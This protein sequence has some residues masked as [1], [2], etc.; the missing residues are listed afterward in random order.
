MLN[1]RMSLKQFERKV[2][3]FSRAP[4][5]CVLTL[6]E[7]NSVEKHRNFFDLVFFKDVRNTRDHKMNFER[8]LPPL[9]DRDTNACNWYCSTKDSAIHFS[10]VLAI[11]D[12]KLLAGILSQS[13]NMH[14]LTDLMKLCARLVAVTSDQNSRNCIFMLSRIWFP[15]Q[16]KCFV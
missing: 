2:W 4:S 9:L 8:L 6:L 13:Q 1:M 15:K 11:H 12:C 16:A 14:A 3:S 10:V 7:R 5:K